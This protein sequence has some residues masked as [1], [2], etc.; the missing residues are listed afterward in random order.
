MK[1]AQWQLGQN[2]SSQISGLPPNSFNH[3]LV[4]AKQLAFEIL[5]SIFSQ[6]RDLALPW[7]WGMSDILLQLSHEQSL[8]NCD[9]DFYFSLLDLIASLVDHFGVG[10]LPVL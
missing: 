5:P 9:F 6:F 2:T 8:K 10:A 1:E 3:L 7:V 4:Y